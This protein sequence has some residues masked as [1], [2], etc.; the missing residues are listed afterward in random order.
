MS[1]SH[2]HYFNNLAQTWDNG[3]E[4]GDLSPYMQQFGVIGGD[5]ILDVGAGTGRLTALLIKLV[6]C[7]GQ[8]VAADL[9]ESMLLRTRQINPLILCICTD[10]CELAITENFFDKV[11]CFATF[12]HIVRPLHA[13]KEMRRVLKP[14][15]RMLILH[16]CCSRKLNQFHAGLEGV[17]CHDHL[18]RA[19]ELQTPIF[20]T[21]LQV[22]KLIER[23]D[24]YWVEMIKP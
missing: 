15:G 17:V 19:E 22:V 16:T 13:L 11:I 23:P 6:G 24:L 21:G 14:G 3:A 20:A 2:R 5:R 18:P 9:A 4:K 10:A 12:P 7:D 8:V 1:L